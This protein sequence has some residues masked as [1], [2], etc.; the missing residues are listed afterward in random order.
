MKRMMIYIHIRLVK[1]DSL[2]SCSSVR[3]TTITDELSGGTTRLSPLFSKFLGSVHTVAAFTPYSWV[4]FWYPKEQP[5]SKVLE[6][7]IQ[8]I[9]RPQSRLDARINYKLLLEILLDL[10]SSKSAVF[11]SSDHSKKADFSSVVRVGLTK[12][13]TL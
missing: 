12:L 11:T 2:L 4:R 1:S 3:I 5:T 8:R 6:Q 7:C 10:S 9:R 13:S